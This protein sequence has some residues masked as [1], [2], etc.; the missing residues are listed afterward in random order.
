MVILAVA[1]IPLVLAPVFFL[2]C[3][4]FYQ[5]KARYLI[6]KGQFREVTFGESGDWCPRDASACS[7]REGLDFGDTEYGEMMHAA[8]DIASGISGLV[9]SVIV[10]FNLENRGTKLATGHYMFGDEV[11]YRD[12]NTGS[13]WALVNPAKP[14]RQSWLVSYPVR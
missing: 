7:R 11:F 13:C 10:R 9:P 14:R 4:F 6:K 8:Q 3:G 2:L 5:Q 12:E 1:T